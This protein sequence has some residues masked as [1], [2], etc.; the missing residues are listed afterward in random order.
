MT[1]QE[2][3]IA[4]KLKFDKLDLLEYPNIEPE[5][6]DFLLNQSQLRLLKTKYQPNN[7]YKVGFEGSQKR[8]DDL[9][10]LVKSASQD[11]LTSYL[12]DDDTNVRIYEATLPTDYFYM[13]KLRVK[14]E[15]AGVGTA[16]KSP[17]QVQHDDISVFISDPFDGPKYR[18]PLAMFAGTKVQIVTDGTFQVTKVFFDYLKKPLDLSIDATGVNTPTGYTNV[19]EF[20]E[21]VHQE[22]VDYAVEMSLENIESPRFQ[23]TQVV[24]L[25]TE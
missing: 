21:Q 24:N 5:A 19:S 11:S 4:F 3:H 17:R 13:V 20:P 23:S 16:I 22:I 18:N 14:V 1:I 9:R 25:K 10:T 6:I 8:I 2:M 15:K 12:M 7:N